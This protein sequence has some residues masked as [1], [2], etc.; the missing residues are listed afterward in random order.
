MSAC[1]LVGINFYPCSW[2]RAAYKFNQFYPSPGE[3]IGG[4]LFWS[5]LVQH[6]KEIGF[7]VPR[8]VDASEFSFKAEELRKTVGSFLHHAVASLLLLQAVIFFSTCRGLRIQVGQVPSIQTAFRSKGMQVHDSYLPWRNSKLRGV[9][10]I[11]LHVQ[12]PGIFHF[13]E[14]N[15]RNLEE[16]IPVVGDAKRTY[17]MNVLHKQFCGYKIQVKCKYIQNKPLWLW[18]VLLSARSRLYMRLINYVVACYLYS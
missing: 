11:W 1:V 14:N 16:F 7:T 18:N 6:A 13:A 17:E 9:L 4:S 12:I 15:A 2:I 3:G 8:L 10:C 5:D